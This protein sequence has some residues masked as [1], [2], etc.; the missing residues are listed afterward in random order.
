V[1]SDPN[2]TQAVSES[3]PVAPRDRGVPE[4]E[5]L[6]AIKADPRLRTLP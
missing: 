6:E 4:E 1:L 5:V 2:D 3:S